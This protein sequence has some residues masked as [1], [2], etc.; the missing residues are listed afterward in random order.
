[1]LGSNIL[2]A[3]IIA[4]GLSTASTA[5]ISGFEYT[6]VHT[7]AHGAIGIEHGID[8]GIPGDIEVDGVIPIKS[9][10]YTVS[11]VYGIKGELG[12]FVL[13]GVGLG[14]RPGE[15]LERTI[16]TGSIGGRP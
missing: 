14:I 11:N 2:V 15:G 12:Q 8:G 13:N 16:S 3:C 6:L 5:E 4:P 7:I 1:M 10:G 9:Y